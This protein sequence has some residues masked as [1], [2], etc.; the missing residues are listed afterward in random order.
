MR[1]CNKNNFVV[2]TCNDALYAVHDNMRSH[3]GGAIS[4]GYGIIHGKSSKQKLNVKSSTEAELV[5]MS[6]YIP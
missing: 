2:F 6:E 4:M 5:G 3:T 1:N